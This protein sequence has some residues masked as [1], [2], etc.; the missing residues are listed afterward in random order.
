MM[1]QL[2]RNN[3]EP[4][5]VFFSKQKSQAFSREQLLFPAP[6]LVVEILS[7]STR[8][9]DYGI[10]FLDY[11]AHRVAEYWIIDPDANTLEQYVLLEDRFELQHKLDSQG[12]LTSLIIPGFR[13]ELAV[14]FAE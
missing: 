7:D 5:I 10:K 12:T 13:M 6:D 8:Q 9:N 3:Y 11:A 4:D 2:S 14:I 1:I